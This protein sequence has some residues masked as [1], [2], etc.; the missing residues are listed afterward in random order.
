M[1]ITNASEEKKENFYFISDF[2]LRVSEIAGNAKLSYNNGRYYI[3]V[4]MDNGEY[5]NY[6]AGD[7]QIQGL[8]H[9]GCRN[10]FARS[11][12]AKMIQSY[13]DEKSQEREGTYE[14]HCND[15]YPWEALNALP[16]DL[17]R[18][19]RSEEI[20]NPDPEKKEKATKL[21]RVSH[22]KIWG[23]HDEPT[24]EEMQEQKRKEQLIM[25]ISNILELSPNVAINTV[26]GRYFISVP[27]MEG[28]YMIYWTADWRLETEKNHI[29]QWIKAPRDI[30]SKALSENPDKEISD[31]GGILMQHDATVR[32]IGYNL[33]NDLGVIYDANQLDEY[34]QRVATMGSKYS[35][36]V[37]TKNTR[38]KDEKHIGGKE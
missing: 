6:S 19:I 31:I 30:N 7:F 8:L 9:R 36:A 27:T 18:T 35:A 37:A 34:L 17:K 16:L 25:L 22:L 15:N 2:A 28:Q 21:S 11:T 33:P 20:G 1:S 12:S 10:I 3:S 13:D 24:D 4:E 26:D 23:G 5:T 38:E 29:F 14:E 32:E